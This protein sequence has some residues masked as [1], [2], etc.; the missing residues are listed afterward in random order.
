MRFSII[1]PCYNTAP[2]LEKCLESI[3]NQTFKDWEIIIVND[4]STD[5]TKSIMKYY[6]EK[7]RRIKGITQKNQGLSAARNQGFKEAKGEYLLFLDSDDWY[8][9]KNSLKY[10]SEKIDDTN[11]D[12]VVFRYQRVTEDGHLYGED[13]NLQ[14]FEQMEESVY[15]G[16]KYLYHVLSQ[17]AVYVWYPWRYTF[18]RSFWIDNDFQFRLCLFEDVDVVYSILLKAQKISILNEVIYQYR[19]VREGSL[20]SISKENMY[21]LIGVSQNVICA[22]NNMNIDEN[23]KKLLRNN[24][25]MGYFTVL[26]EVNYLKKEDRKE[27]FDILDKN[28]SLMNDTTRKKNLMIKGLISILGLHIT[29][30]LLYVRQKVRKSAEIVKN[31]GHLKDRVQ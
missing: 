25:S 16:E 8:K 11:P 6:E 10:L 30:K 9:G 7:D 24:F 27:V 12:I 18:R 31:N 5:N 22:V 26:T 29:S 14:C 17:S 28:R 23:L 2:Y 20:T 3:I 19:T 4:G 15:S 1:I 13:C 21:G